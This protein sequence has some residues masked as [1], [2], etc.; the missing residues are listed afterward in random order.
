MHNR[1]TNRINFKV[2]SRT[3]R[4]RIKEYSWNTCT[5]NLTDN[6]NE[7]LR[8]T[9]CEIFEIVYEYRLKPLF[10]FLPY[11]YWPIQFFWGCSIKLCTLKSLA[12]WFLSSS[13]W[14][15][16]ALCGLKYI[17]YALKLQKKRPTKT[18]QDQ[19]AGD[20]FILAIKW[21][22]LSVLLSYCLRQFNWN[23]KRFRCSGW[24]L[25]PR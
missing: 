10:E 19:M 23:L 5:S 16:L 2:I 17:G 4:I 7:F 25:Q 6:L 9:A 24:I 14:K 3:E 13:V 12:V 11:S 21:R 22:C 1:K 18:R 15:Q 20:Q 8:K